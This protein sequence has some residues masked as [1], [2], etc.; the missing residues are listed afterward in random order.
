MISLKNIQ[1]TMDGPGGVV[2]ILRGI[3][4]DIAA[5]EVVSITG[6]SGSGKTSMMMVIAGLEKATS[7][8]IEVNG[9]NLTNKNEDCLST[10]RR[11]NMGIVF[12]NFHLIPTM[13]A[14]QNVAMPAEFAGVPDAVERARLGLN[15]VGL[16]Q[17]LHHF[18]SQ[19][20]GGEQQRVALA[21][22]F[23]TRPK[24]LLADEPTGNLDRET[25][26]VIIDLL[27]RL[28]RDHGTTLVLITHD[29]K[30]SNKCMREICINDGLVSSDRKMA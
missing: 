24:V 23:S 14:L 17:R 20:S 16:N 21:R 1:L 5:G 28:A 9:I 25:G 12:Q 30:I 15:L 29:H 18:P 4:F 26:E 8:V 13:D 22:A 7:G 6:P 11:E 2:N 10:F 19:L 3:S 27:L